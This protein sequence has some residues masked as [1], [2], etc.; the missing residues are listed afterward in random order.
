MASSSNQAAIDNSKKQPSTMID[1]LSGL[2]KAQTGQ[3]VSDQN[4][5]Q[6]LINNMTTLVQQG[7]LSQAQIV[8]VR[9]I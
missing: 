3:D 5:A 8:Q 1:V 9:L 4:V 7:K 6:L 2:L